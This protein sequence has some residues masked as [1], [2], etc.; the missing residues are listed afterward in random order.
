MLSICIPVYNFDVTELVKALNS[1]AEELHVSYEILVI[2][3]A[4]QNLYKLDVY[5][6]QALQL[7]PRTIGWLHRLQLSRMH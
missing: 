2:D 4:S 7:S 1:Q 6:R 3:D 5:K